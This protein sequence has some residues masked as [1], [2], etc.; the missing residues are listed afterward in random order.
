MAFLET[1]RFPDDISRWLVG[2]R[3]FNTIVVRTYGGLE[4]R[5]AQW[6]YAA[7]EWDVAEAMRVVDEQAG[8][9]G[10]AWAAL[11]NLF[12]ASQGMLNGFRVKIFDD[13][14]DDS[15]GVL[16]TTGV[17]VAATTAYQMFK[18][19][20]SGA[21]SY[22]GKILKP[23]ASTIKVYVNSVLKT[24]TTDY[25]INAATGVVTLTS[26]PTV[27]H[28][29]TWTGEFDTPCRFGGDIPANGLDS[30]GSVYVWSGLKLVEL[31]NP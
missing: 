15:A 8:S 11:R 3:G 4:Y 13:Y 1:P 27:G 26:Q 17:G 5:N 12:M 24:L 29:L 19:Y 2:G 23:V 7:G 16:G 9:S 22:Q 14:K 10:Y 28:T 21:N 25:T 31:K 30:S 20:A 18:N 6:A